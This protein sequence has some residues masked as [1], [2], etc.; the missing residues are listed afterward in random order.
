M[1]D[2]DIDAVDAGLRPVG[3]LGLWD[4]AGTHYTFTAYPVRA[5]PA[6]SD[7]VYALCRLEGI[8]PVPLMV[9]SADDLGEAL[10]DA[11]MLEDAIALGAVYLLVHR[12]EAG[13][14]VGHR[15]AAARLVR[16]HRPPLNRRVPG[17][18]APAAPAAG[19]QAAS[20]KF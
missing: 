15:E 10:A 7:A 9:A 19:Q 13:D 20:R 11:G 4:G 16:A 14:P 12:P 18:R 5:R 6:A 17:R 8:L 3:S 1:A 2:G